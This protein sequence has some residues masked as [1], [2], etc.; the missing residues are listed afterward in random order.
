MS[1][2]GKYG[3]KSS[4][5]LFSRPGSLSFSWGSSPLQGTLSL[6]TRSL[7]FSPRGRTYTTCSHT[8]ETTLN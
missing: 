7:P 1:T 5:N 3:T 4:K 8:T 2:Y 6:F